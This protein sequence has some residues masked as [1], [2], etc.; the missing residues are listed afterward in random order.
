[1][2]NTLLLTLLATLVALALSALTTL[3]AALS[4]ILLLLTRLLLAAAL[5]AALAT[6]TALPAA[7]VLLSTL[8]ATLI[9]LARLLFIG[10]H[11]CFSNFLPVVTTS[12]LKRSSFSPSVG[13]A[14]VEPNA[15]DMA[16]INCTAG[17]LPDNR[18][19]PFA[20]KARPDANWRQMK[21]HQRCNCSPNR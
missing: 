10:V 15:C 12:A 5:L 6:L 8:L 7:L 2:Q 17:N 9:L 11:V 16:R 13:Q 3:L 18:V 19:A 21:M 14:C 1:V 4:R 20:A